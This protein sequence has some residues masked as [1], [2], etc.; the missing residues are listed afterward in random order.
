MTQ[1][2][3]RALSIQALSQALDAPDAEERRQATT[4]LGELELRDA[5]PLLMRA[6][7]DSDWRVRKEAT[8]GA[9]AFMPDRMLSAALIE[10][11]SQGENVGLRNAAVEVLASSGHATAVAVANA[12]SSLDEV[13]RKLAVEALGRS[14]DQAALGP[15]EAALFDQDDN[16]RQAAVEA[17]ASVGAVAGEPAHKL[18]LRCLRDEDRFIRL[19]ALE[20]LNSLGVAISWTELSPL[21]ADP[22]TRTAALLAAALAEH[23]QAPAALV[24]A[25]VSLRGGAFAQTMTALARLAEGKLA[26]DVAAA[27]RV[28]G[29]EL[30]HKLGEMAKGAQGEPDHLR[31]AALV[32]SALVFAPGIA[33][34]AVAAL[35]EHSLANAASRALSMLGTTALAP[36]IERIS[37]SAPTEEVVATQIRA[38]SIDIAATIAHEQP[39]ACHTE[40]PLLLT[41]LRLAARDR[42]REVATNAVY[43]LSHIGNE[44]DLGLMAEL[45]LNPDPSVAS[46]A[47]SALATLSNRCPEQAALLCK[48]LMQQAVPSLAATILLGALTYDDDAPKSARREHLA[49]LSNCAAS[50]DARTRRAA[51]TALARIGG[52]FAGDALTV[53]LSDEDRDVQLEAARAL[54]RVCADPNALLFF[55]SGPPSGPP[56][57]DRIRKS[58]TDMLDLL[59]RS[60]DSDLVA[61]AVHAL[62]DEMTTWSPASMPPSSSGKGSGRS[63]SIFPADDLVTALAP[64]AAKAPSSVAIAAVDALSRAPI[65]TP[66][67]MNALLSAL[68]HPNPAV[69]KAAMLKLDVND[70]T[71]DRIARCLEHLSHEIRGLAVEMLTGEGNAKIRRRFEETLRKEQ[72][73]EVREAIER[74]LMLIPTSNG[75]GDSP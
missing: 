11:L 45:L 72:H 30:I 22:T 48:D 1:P 10:A 40:L 69:V 6:L 2:R 75:R 17:I 21:L 29:P 35:G 27:L 24:R 31:A 36:L 61:A 18:L 42:E 50:G 23:P 4:H 37:S 12:I 74:A 55:D 59:E 28:Q 19:A 70:V 49:F 68:G 71:R 67:A 41:A 46:A 20:G 15:L 3:E 39:D 33:E 16:V 66:G 47:E 57:S 44:A 34:V 65:G 63:A 25:L 43:A 64:L 73:A 13:G 8:I 60:G 53:A 5:L 26:F 58:A 7:G 62:G 32:L 14:R 52:P 38:A 9:R 51:I 54:G 56:S